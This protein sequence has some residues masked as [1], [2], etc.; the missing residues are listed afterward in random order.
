MRWSPPLLLALVCC[1][2]DPVTLRADVPFEASDASAI[3]ALLRPNEAPELR[4]FVIEDGAIEPAW[5]LPVADTDRW[6]VQ[7]LVYDVPLTELGLEAGVL[8]PVTEG[9]SRALPSPARVLTRQLANRSLLD[10]WETSA[11]I[12]ADVAA[13]RLPLVCAT[14]D[15]VEVDLP[16][17][18]PAMFLVA[19]DDARLLMGNRDG[20]MYVATPDGALEPITSTVG[21][22]YDAFADDAGD[23]YLAAT[24]G[25]VVH[26]RV[27]ADRLEVLST[28]SVGNDD[29]LFIDG[30]TEVGSEVR[31]VLDTERAQRR[32]A[33]GWSRIFGFGRPRGIAS[34]G[35]GL[36][37]AVVGY[38]PFAWTF[39]VMD[40][41]DNVTDSTIA[42]GVTSLGRTPMGIVAG[43]E[44]GQLYR[45][46]G[47]DDWTFLEGLAPELLQIRGIAAYEDGFVYARPDGVLQVVEGQACPYVTTVRRL[48]ESSATEIGVPVEDAARDGGRAELTVVGRAIAVL[49]WRGPE[50]DR[51]PQLWWFR[52]RS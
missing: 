4:A 11:P 16:D 8:V 9:A 18:A 23:L 43:T 26:A 40:L 31:F 32:D 25:L 35:G 19:L 33:S 5:N 50:N 20:A 42:G 7:V 41:E 38:N 21:L 47:N 44:Y 36:G 46:N 6:K 28:E 10:N 37:R 29:V 24:D 14:F 17:D 3:V 15:P 1:A 45:R 48:G 22:V 12:D 34:I 27:V 2:P 39:D 51:K 30:E 49:V 13:L 52:P